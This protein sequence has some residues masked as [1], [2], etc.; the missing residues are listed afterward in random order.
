MV[1][2]S[3]RFGSVPLPARLCHVG[4]PWRV[5]AVGL[6]LDMVVARG[7]RAHS[8]M[9]SL[10]RSRSFL[11]PA[12]SLCPAHSHSHSRILHVRLQCCMLQAC[13]NVGMHGAATVL[14]F[15]P[16]RVVAAHC[17]TTLPTL[18]PRTAT[19]TNIVA[20][21][22]N[23]NLSTAAGFPPTPPCGCCHPSPP[24]TPARYSD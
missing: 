14:Q 8:H 10:T 22:R 24:P 3:G 21:Y 23:H 15:V 5:L 2:L 19:R 4:I 6:M 11:R 18:P 7:V 17:M 20:R 16:C 9:L 12:L 13:F 1:G